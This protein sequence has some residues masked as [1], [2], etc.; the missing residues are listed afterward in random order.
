MT[1]DR[2][3]AAGTRCRR[4]RSARAGIE[5]SR[6][7]LWS[8]LGTGL[9]VLLLAGT[10]RAA[11]SPEGRIQ[12]LLLRELARVSLHRSPAQPGPTIA[13][14]ESP[15]APDPRIP[16]DAAGRWICW[17]T[18]A[19][20]ATDPTGALAAQ[21]GLVVDGRSGPTLQV[22]VA[23]ERLRELSEVP[24][25]IHV[26][27]PL[28]PVPE[29]RSEALDDMRVGEF[30]ALGYDGEGVRVGIIDV[31][32]FGYDTRLGGELP[33]RVEARSFFGSANGSGDIGG[34]G[35]VH[36]TACAEIVHDVAP[37]A[38]LY[39]ANVA[40]AFDLGNAVDWMVGAGVEV[41]SHSLAWF[42]GG[43]DGTGPVDDIVTRASDAGILWVTSAGN[44]AQNHW[45]GKYADED[46]DG[47]IETKP[48]GVEEIQIRSDGQPIHLILLWDRWPTSTDLSFQ[49]ELYDGDQIL[50][51]SEPDYGDYPYAFR[52]LLYTPTTAPVAPAFRIRYIGGDPTGTNLRVFLLGR[53]SLAPADQVRAGSI[54]VP[55]DSPRTIAVGAYSWR[56]REL[57]SFSSFGPTLTGL[58]KP[59]ITG[60]SGV[61]TATYGSQAFAGTSAAC[62]HVAGAVA[63]L[64]SAS[65]QGGIYEARWGDE[66][67]RR[68]LRE[69]ALPLQG[70]PDPEAVGW[71]RVRLFLGDEG[72]SPAARLEAA[73]I[74]TP[75]RLVFRLE[76]AKGRAPGPL[77]VYD[78]QGRLLATVFPSLRLPG[79]SSYA[80]E[81]GEIRLA[82]GR[83]W[84]W[85]PITGART[86]FFWSGP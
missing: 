13:D 16:V 71:G 5:R 40:T 8:L 21:P 55:A 74:D 24:G 70:S 56:S 45:A 75:G 77:R 25:V 69:A 28:R 82:R 83:Y 34:G 53:G 38:S 9:L 35:E 54:T 42:V 73:G 86:A 27:V 11:P 14:A 61:S 85:E 80:L 78:V 17:L 44:F 23:P 46:E 39:L 19:S 64:L 10:V 49:I 79:R 32:F 47:W 37:G 12:P 15:N 33:P 62:P 57:A 48:G 58:Q 18:V 63:L 65:V 67:I 76:D 20:D 36:G 60:P 6:S 41:I 68:M 50:A 59:E 7:R 81:S 22:H 43:G 66:E 29:I 4:D 1:I 51:S 2:V 72:K 31:G 26:G 3:S 30:Q 52:E 84:A